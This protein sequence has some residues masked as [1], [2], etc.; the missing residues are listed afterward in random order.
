MIMDF[1]PLILFFSLKASAAATLSYSNNTQSITTSPVS[2]QASCTVSALETFWE[3]YPG[4]VTTTIT[5]ATVVYIVNNRTNTTT[6]STIFNDLPAGYTLPPTNSKGSQTAIITVETAESKYVT[7][8]VYVLAPI[9]SLRFFRLIRHR[10]FPTG[11]SQLGVDYTWEGVLPTVNSVGQ[12]VCSSGSAVIPWS[13][14]GFTYPDIAS[15]TSSDD[16]GG[17]MWW[18]FTFTCAGQMPK[19]INTKDAALMLCDH[20]GVCPVAEKQVA[21][22]LT[23]TSTSHVNSVPSATA[24]V[25]PTSTTA[26]A[27]S[28][29]AQSVKSAASITPTA[30]PASQPAPVAPASTAVAPSPLVIASSASVVAS[31]SGTTIALQ[32]NTN[33]NTQVIVNGISSALPIAS[34]AP[35]VAP[36]VVAGSTYSASVI[37]SAG[38]TSTV[39]NIGGQTLGVGTSIV[40]GS[41]PSATTIALQTNANGN[42]QV[43]VNGISSAF[44]TASTAPPVAPVVI[45]GS[46]YYASVVTSTGGTSTVYNIGGQTLD[47]GSSIVLGSG[48]SATTIALETNV[49]GNTQ[50]V[51]NGK[52]STLPGTSTAPSVAPIVVA[53]VTVTP[54]VAPGGNTVLNIGGHTLTLGSSITLGSGTSA[55]TIAYQVSSGVTEV[56]VNGHTS[57]LSAAITSNRQSVGVAILSGIGGI[58]TGANSSPVARVTGANSLSASRVTGASSSSAAAANGGRREEAGIWLIVCTGF[59]ALVLGFGIF[60]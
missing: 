2:C 13:S 20:V 18:L 11:V 7:T 5:A 9:Q 47:V 30:A 55:T 21:S 40:L 6:T 14:T 43:I 44:P 27:A 25:N 41:G 48:P 23:E 19:G 53:G 45:A 10:T 26:I 4:S 29:A 54:S 49:N 59:M 1:I 37:T 35:S 42:T 60:A 33:G 16:P 32:T 31:A 12:S 15:S 38:G 34:T 46:T 36:V 3:W 50:V 22:Y 58:P 8:T 39:Y 57:T 56:V 28:V 52:T 17:L 24:N 51:V